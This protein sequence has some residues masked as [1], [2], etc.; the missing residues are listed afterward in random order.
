M[1]KQNV[2]PLKEGWQ[3]IHHVLRGCKQFWTDIDQLL[4]LEVGE[5]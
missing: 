5:K 3:N 4:D 2:P 1:L